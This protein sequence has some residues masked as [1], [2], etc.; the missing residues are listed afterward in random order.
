MPEKAGLARLFCLT[1][2]RQGNIIPLL[3]YEGL[4]MKTLIEFLRFWIP[5]LRLSPEARLAGKGGRHGF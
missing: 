5:R 4:N 3:T 1:L 2:S